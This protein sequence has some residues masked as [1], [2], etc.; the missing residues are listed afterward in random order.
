[1]IDARSG[2][3][4]GF[5]AFSGGVYGRA[6]WQKDGGGFWIAVFGS[7]AIAHVSLSSLRVDR[8]IPLASGGYP[9]SVALS[10]DGAFA[11][12]PE[13]LG[14]MVSIVRLQD[15]VTLSNTAAGYRPN[16]V[17]WSNDGH[18][19]YAALWGSNAVAAIDAASGRVIARISTGLHPQT[20]AGTGRLRYVLAADDDRIDVIDTERRQNMAHVSIGLLPELPAGI[21][22]S[23]AVIDATG[24]RLYAVCSTA[25]AVAVFSLNAERP[26]LL[27]AIPTGWFPTDVAISGER[28]F[29][30]NGR[31][32]G[33]AANPLY[34]PFSI[35][36]PHRDEFVGLYLKGSLRTRP[37]PDSAQLQSGLTAV[38][39]Q[40]SHDVPSHPAQ[41]VVRPNG[42]ITHIIF[43][44]KEN[45][46]YD[47]V[48]GDLGIGDG[49]PRLT[50]FGET[51][52]PNEH[53]IARRLGVFDRFFASG[54]VTANGL[55]WSTAA[56]ANDYDETLWP[57]QYA[58]RGMPY[59]FEDGAIAGRPHAGY[60]WMQ[61]RAR[62]SP[63]AITACGSPTVGLSESLRRRM[64]LRSSVT[65]IRVTAASIWTKATRTARR[66]DS[67]NS[68]SSNAAER[69]PRWRSSG[70]PTTTR[71][72]RGPVPI[73]RKQ[74]SPTTISP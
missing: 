54:Q 15:G 2:R 31:G 27:G 6:A 43:I 38:R 60:L 13:L 68:S 73:P 10:P 62:T 46:T 52:T 67:G 7:D 71:P 22:P 63:T 28:V 24:Q 16:G 57:A 17:S 21:S 44:V 5:V 45:R 41:S 3:V 18:T 34:N 19:V 40:R 42:P 32:E 25:N 35:T 59:D 50:L 29:I 55:N 37:V 47:Q 8:T 9:V 69:C 72:A 58:H 48:F 39:A 66:N 33:S 11:A 70:C 20:I 56:F 51:I 36:T 65:S 64:K 14:G 74:W 53:A 49:D 4:L 23:A 30:V 26:T 61:P 1:M 12:V